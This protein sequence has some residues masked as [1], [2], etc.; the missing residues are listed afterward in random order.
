[1]KLKHLT[2]NE[3]VKDEINNEKVTYKSKKYENIEYNVGYKI[4]NKNKNVTSCP[5]IYK[6]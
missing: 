3:T 2:I 5:N 6:K 4:W 1:M